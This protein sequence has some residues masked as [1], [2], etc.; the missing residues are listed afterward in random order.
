[1][2]R[3]N[4]TSA[5]KDAR[6]TRVTLVTR[7]YRPEASAA[8]LRLGALVDAL[9]QEGTRVRVLT[10]RVPSGAG[11]DGE[12]GVSR[13]PVLRD[14]SG[15]VRGYLPYLSFDLPVFFRIVLESA[16]DVY[17]CEPPPTTGVAVRAALLLR[18]RPYVYYAADIWSDAAA[19]TTASGLV[20]R[21]VGAMERFAMRGAARVLAVTE[22][23]AERVRQ[24]APRAQVSVVGHGVDLSRF[25]PNGSMPTERAD[26][27]YV[28]SASE[29][30][31][32]ELALDA[33][34]DVMRERPDLSAAFIGQG[35]SWPAL[36][37]EAQRQGMAE[38]IQFLDTVS[39]ERAAEWLRGARVS[40]ATLVPGKGYDFAVPTK[41]YA[42][43]AV[44]TPVVYAGPS[45]VGDM[46]SA[47]RLGIAAG[48]DHG[49]MTAALRQALDANDGTADP[50]LI[51][52][53]QSHVA[54]SAVAR[55]AVDAVTPLA[56]TRRS[57]PPETFDT[58][59]PE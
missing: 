53:A 31:G 21:V 8:S 32:A 7:I 13:W 25:A 39:P 47:H 41:L 56:R 44:G 52:W 12:P 19:A 5:R 58:E 23:V 48:Y 22:G 54:S 35:A 34:V 2:G 4:T 37:A 1:M 20:L 45:G 18:R 29:W 49:E 9:R 42:S 40:L 59:N 55:R 46:I 11:S 14:S 28:G 57:A 33:L 17:L 10:T 27:V 3:S 51:A 50:H 16:A 24:L 43:V 38:R 15:Y 30:H 36:K 26:V 6:G